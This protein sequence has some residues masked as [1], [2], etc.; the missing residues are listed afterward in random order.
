MLLHCQDDSLH[1]QLQ[2]FCRSLYDPNIRLMRDQEVDVAELYAGT[3]LAFEFERT[4]S[5]LIEMQSSDY[6]A[7]PHLA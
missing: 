6:L 3:R 5:R 1:R 2:T 4:I 7:L